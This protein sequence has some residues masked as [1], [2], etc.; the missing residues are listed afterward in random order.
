MYLGLL[1]NVRS[2]SVLPVQSG[3]RRTEGS[4]TAGIHKTEYTIAMRIDDPF[5][6]NWRTA[7]IARRFHRASMV[8]NMSMALAAFDGN[9]GK[10]CAF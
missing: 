5:G 10:V 3:G 9:V 6:L 8:S 7:I 2:S 1:K 4:S